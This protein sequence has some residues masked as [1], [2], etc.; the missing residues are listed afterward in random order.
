MKN[1]TTDSAPLT[2][3]AIAAHP[4]DIEFAM[5][6]TLLRLK[7]SGAS[8]HLW[9]LSGGSGGTA[10]LDRETITRAR[11]QEARDAAALAGAV[12]Y[13]PISDDF[14]IFYNREL[15]LQVGARV[16][17]IKPDIILTHSLEDYMEDHQNTARLA[18]TGAFSRA[19][20]N[21]ITQPPQPAWGGNTAVYHAMPHGLQDCMRRRVAIEGYADI[22]PYIGDKRA[23]LA[24]HRSQKEWLDQTQGMDA[25]LD[26]MERFALLVGKRSG[27][28]TAAE[29]WR[30]HS[31][32][33]FGPETADPLAAALGQHYHID[34]AYA[35]RLNA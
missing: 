19:S 5:A 13:P 8:I 22:T 23:M 26:A 29:G 17:E 3:L 30:R 28:F 6:G 34:P 20:I 18:V 2:V 33:G 10:T 1:N 15:L 16:R 25:Y 12:I 27:C 11:W 14:D 32:L 7:A 31:A 24:C 21:F 4:D 9:N 35:Q